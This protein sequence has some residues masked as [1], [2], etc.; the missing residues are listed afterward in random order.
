MTT[1]FT[2]LRNLMCPMSSKP[3]RCPSRRLSISKKGVAALV[4]LGV[5][6]FNAPLPAATTAT[7]PLLQKANLIYEGA[8]RVPNAGASSTNTFDYGGTAL[9][10]N[11]INNSIFLTGHDWYQRTAEL[12]IPAIVNSSN[13]NSLNTATLLQGFSD[14]TEGKL[15]SINSDTTN[16]AKI[17]GHL[18]Y[19]NKLIVTGYSYYDSSGSQSTSHFTRPLSLSTTGQVTGPY[20]VGSDPHFTDGYMTLIPPEW[21]ASFGGPALTGMCCLSITSVQSNGPSISVFNPNL[22]T[23]PATRLLGYPLSNPLRDGSTTNSV[24]NLTAKVSG[25]VFP[26]G[27][28]SVL[29]FG[30]IGVGTYCYGEGSTC[31]DPADPS[32]GTHAYPYV[33]Q[34]WAYDANDLLAVKNGTKQQYQP[35]PYA[36]WSFTLPFEDNLNM[37]YLGGAAYDPATNRIYVSQLSSDGAGPVIHVFQVQGGTTVT[38]L[39][40]PTNLRVQ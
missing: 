20:L 8:F 16:A 2:Q 25:V 7:L 13:L 33:Y 15:D 35:Q 1:H 29:F 5:F 22:T 32:K 12:K 14:E 3:E 40:P 36:I 31:N 10:F 34:V 37:H 9:G 6:T 27:T 30:R 19:N 28:R 38:T 23:Q 39:P 18:V 24:Y 17:G 4:A 26:N 21:Q 11:P